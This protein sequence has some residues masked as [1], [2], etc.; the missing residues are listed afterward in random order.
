MCREV[1]RDV[2]DVSRMCRDCVA[3][4]RGC[5]VG[6]RGRVADVLRTC[7]EVSRGVTECRGAVNV[8][9]LYVNASTRSKEPVALPLAV[10]RGAEILKP[11]EGSC[12]RL[13]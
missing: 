7:R 1:S 5:V 8:L 6:C 9:S 3:R 4:C 10:A 11:L 12:A 13:P 2:A